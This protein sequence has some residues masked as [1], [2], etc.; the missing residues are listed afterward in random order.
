MTLANE[1]NYRMLVEKIEDLKN[2][3]D[4][5]QNLLI[6]KTSYEHIDLATKILGSV[7]INSM[8]SPHYLGERLKDYELLMLNVKQMGYYLGLKEAELIGADRQLSEPKLLSEVPLQSKLCTQS[9]CESEWYFAWLQQLKSSFLYHRKLWEFA[10]I[11]QNLY[12]FGV[13]KPG[14]RGLGFGCGEEP[15]ASLFAK[16]GAVI[17]ATD[18]DPRESEEQGHGWIEAGAH[19]SSLEKLYHRNVCPD[20]TLLSN[21]NHEFANMNR[22]PKHYEGQFDFCWSSCAMEHIG[23]IE[24]GLRFIEN[25]METLRSGGVS[26]HTTEYN[27][28]DGPTIDNW[29]T[30]LFQRSHME[31]LKTRLEAKGYMV[32]AFDFDGGGKVLDGLF[33]I[34]PWPWDVA[35]LNWRMLQAITHLKRSIDGFRCTSIGVTVR[36]A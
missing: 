33:D 30:V 10:Y 29:Q 8:P 28:D 27:L 31:E 3:V 12:A 36:K 9:D 35:K 7:S 22:I 13:L 20:K 19:S 21:I 2:K 15:L 24:L 32:S 17:V 6:E 25:S 5:L 34:P 16:F 11:A 14:K 23:S 1:N 18:L 4:A 26:V